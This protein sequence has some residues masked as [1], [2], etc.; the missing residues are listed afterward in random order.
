MEDGFMVVPDVHEWTDREWTGL[1]IGGDAY[2]SNENFPYLTAE[3]I[4][5]MIE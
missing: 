2:A 4:R 5:E 3:E 1:R